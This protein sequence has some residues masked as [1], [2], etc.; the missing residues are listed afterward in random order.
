MERPVFIT[1]LP[2]QPLLPSFLRKLRRPRIRL[3][4]FPRINPHL[5]VSSDPTP[6]ERR[7]FLTLP[8]RTRAR[9]KISKRRVS[10]DLSCSIIRLHPGRLLPGPW[11]KVEVPWMPYRMFGQRHPSEFHPRPRAWACLTNNSC[12]NK[13]QFH[14]YPLPPTPLKDFLPAFHRTILRDR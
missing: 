2:T 13:N 8:I 10:F 7:P 4:S 11:A 12:N 6:P 14:L 1:F 5:P 9:R 3:V